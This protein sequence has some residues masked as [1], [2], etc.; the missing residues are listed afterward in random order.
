MIPPGPV[1][2]LFDVDGTLIAPRGLGRR[3]LEQAAS[4]LGLRGAPL[5][6]GDL[7]GNTDPVILQA[8]ARAWGGGPEQERKLRL[9]YLR[10]MRHELGPAGR[11]S[12]RILA[13]ASALVR[14][15][16]REPHVLLGLATGN[17][18]QVARLKLEAVRLWPAFRCG[19]FGSDHPD[20]SDIVRCA[21]RRAQRLSRGVRAQAT[22]VIGDTPR[23]V[24]AARAAGARAVAVAS[25]PYSRAELAVAGPDLLL[26]SLRGSARLLR[27]VRRLGDDGGVG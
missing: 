21:V 12:I 3:A 25:G 13:G 7:A 1:L 4:G 2:V 26:G 10:L 18:R 6:I 5:E 19:G 23:D 11:R 9:A 24:A 16:A 14:R 17:L 22:V 8:L 15:L 27:L 20:R